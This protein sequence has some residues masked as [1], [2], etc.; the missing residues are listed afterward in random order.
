MFFCLL[1]WKRNAGGG[2][3]GKK[4]LVMDEDSWSRKHVGGIM[5]EESS[6]RKMEEES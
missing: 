6:R 4:S 5:K 3:T 2:N 1:S